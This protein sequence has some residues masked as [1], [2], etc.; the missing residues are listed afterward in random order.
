[1]ARCHVE[2]RAQ[3]VVLSYH[4]GPRTELRSLRSM[5]NVLMPLPIEPSHRP[6]ESSLKFF[7]YETESPQKEIPI[8]QNCNFPG[9]ANISSPQKGKAQGGKGKGSS[10]AQTGEPIN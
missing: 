10:H 9:T 4:T 5:A 3:F 8:P 7:H 6:P 1:M 2:V